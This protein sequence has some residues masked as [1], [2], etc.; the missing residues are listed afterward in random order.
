M[1]LNFLK[2]T[3]SCLIKSEERTKSAQT[4]SCEKTEKLEETKNINEEGVNDIVESRV[5]VVTDNL[6]SRNSVGVCKPWSSMRKIKRQSKD[7]TISRNGGV[8]TKM[9]RNT[10]Y[11]STPSLTRNEVELIGMRKR[12]SEGY[13]FNVDKVE[14]GADVL[15]YTNWDTYGSLITLNFGDEE[16]NTRSRSNSCNGQINKIAKRKSGKMEKAESYSDSGVSSLYET[17]LK[18]QSL[19]KHSSDRNL[20]NW[21]IK[22]DPRLDCM[23]EKYVHKLEIHPKLFPIFL[24]KYKTPIM[25]STFATPLNILDHIDNWTEDVSVFSNYEENVADMKQ[26]MLMLI[27]R[28]QQV[29]RIKLRSLKKD[30]AF[31][32]ESLNLALEDLTSELNGETNRLLS[33]FLENL[34]AVTDLVFA[35]EM[36]VKNY[37]KLQKINNNSHIWRY[38]LVEAMEIKRKYDEDL[39]KVLDSLEKESQQSL[40]NL[41]KEMQRL[42]CDIRILNDELYYLDMQMKILFPSLEL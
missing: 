17:I 9:R 40:K 41:I 37:S 29:L 16:N 20:G 30:K 34:D 1:L 13:R 5:Q 32:D 15:K 7:L 22:S 11:E 38:K 36:K 23:L 28:Q 8:K 18:Y 10:H 21:N 31:L 25:T 2:R 19:P 42:T 14:T 12:L 27:A 35:L 6:Y 4:Y 39:K 33:R 24:R 3:K 26:K